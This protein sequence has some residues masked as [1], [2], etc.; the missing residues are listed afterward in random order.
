MKAVKV[1]L[2]VLAIGFGLPVWATTYY[3]SP[4]GGDDG[5]SPERPT[6]LADAVAK[7]TAEGAGAVV[8]LSADTFEQTAQVTIAAD[9]I[10]QGAG[11]DK[12]IVTKN[13][14]SK[15]RLFYLNSAGA[16]LKDMTVQNGN[17]EGSGGNILID[18]NGGLVSNC[19]IRN[20][21]AKNNG[22]GGGGIA[23]K[24]G[25]VVDSIITNNTFDSTQMYEH[26][27]G[28]VYF[29]G[30]SKA[31]IRRCVVAR[32]F[33]KCSGNAIVA[34]AGIGVYSSGK[35]VVIDSCTIA[36]NS[37]S[38]SG[39]V[40]SGC[41]GTLV[42]NCLFTGNISR[43][44][45][46]DYADFYNKNSNLTIKDCFF[47]ADAAYT[48]TNGKKGYVAFED[49]SFTPNFASDNVG[50]AADGSDIGAVQHRPV[51]ALTGYID[52]STLKY[53]APVEVTLTAHATDEN[54]NEMTA[55]V[56]DF[57]DNS[58]SASGASVT[59]D[60]SVA[61]VYTPKATVTVDGVSKVISGKPIDVGPGVV[62]VSS[63]GDLKAAVDSAYPG[64]TVRVGP[65][66]YTLSTTTAMPYD[67]NGSTSI[68][69]CKPVKVIAESVNPYDTV[70]TVTKDSTRAFYLN[71]DAALV[72]GFTIKGGKVNGT[73]HFGG[74]VLVDYGMVSN[75]VMCGC[76]STS[77]GSGGAGVGM[78]HGLVTH[79]II[80]NNTSTITDYDNNG[81]AVNVYGG[82]MRNCLIS[83]NTGKNNG[84]KYVNVGGVSMTGGT[85]ENCTIAGNSAPGVGGVWLRS[86]SP[87]VRN[88]A[89]HDNSSTSGNITYDQLRGT[90]SYFVNCASTVAISGG[91]KCVKGNI[92]VASVAKQ[93]WH[94]QIGTASIGIGLV[95]GWMTD[96]KD[97]DGN[98]M[99]SEEGK[100]DAG[101]W[102]FQ[103]TYL[104][105][106][107]NA[108]S[109][110]GVY[111]HAVVLTA[112]GECEDPITSYVWTFG[113][114]SPSETTTTGAI[115]HVY[116]SAGVYKPSVKFVVESTGRSADFQL[117]DPID[118]GYP[119]FYVTD[120]ENAGTA[121]PWG[122]W[123]TATT[124]LEEVIPYAKNGSVITLSAGTHYTVGQVV[125][126]HGVT[127]EGFDD[128]PAQT[129]VTLKSGS[130][131]HRLFYIDHPKAVLRG[132]AAQ[133]NK[134]EYNVDGSVIYVYTSGG[135]V[136]NC[137]IRGGYQ[138]SNGI[139]GGGII[140]F[141]GTLT[142][143]VVSN[144]VG[145]STHGYG[146][147]GAA[148]ALWGNSS[149]VDYC[150]ITG[151]RTWCTPGGTG[152]E[153][154]NGANVLMSGGTLRNCTIV[155]N[156]AGDNESK[157]DRA[158]FGGVSVYSTSEQNKIV[159][160][161][162]ASN[163]SYGAVG[164]STA[165]RRV[166]NGNAINVMRDC[167]TDVD[168]GKA[169]CFFAEDMKF[170]DA[171]NG[172][173]RVHYQSVAAKN[174][175]ASVIKATRDL[176]GAPTVY[177][178]NK[179]DIGCY[180]RADKPGM[181]LMVR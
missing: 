8:Q 75:C 153:G 142:H 106:F 98:P 178:R 169:S 141:S 78:Y 74:A 5:S 51:T 17:I 114:G 121:F 110:E 103:S 95:Q 131:K 63:G 162:I 29:V 163:T 3:A 58:A 15:F 67:V 31:A 116:A 134:S 157:P 166:A 92:N 28:A 151:N 115:A 40:Y 132:L 158:G 57:G 12:T 181:V 69:L 80:S 20:G 107:L 59:H 33:A 159:N 23:L 9:I 156:R 96:A 150:L 25:E 22:N 36:Y 102:Q 140:L 97:L 125:L 48:G 76:T 179:A 128:D 101:C 135:T 19:V 32:N 111:P 117:A 130:A 123:T 14:S 86:G 35:G 94:P 89:I 37:G 119:H 84:G 138:A 104:S 85:L 127:V 113:D 7:A 55:C 53:A 177:L 118:V 30:S 154:K 144:N 49:N 83:N 38:R 145:A 126:K 77:N 173:W 170:V 122:D 47:D 34:T 65:G 62:S 39:G 4:A 149:L 129:V 13:A 6:T 82:T 108:D 147:S 171:A 167:A 18:T 44:V 72:S 68:Q 54:G 137:I 61:G 26:S 146:H 2:A 79:S 93:D 71:D 21:A 143:S 66:P 105:G 133:G 120:K 172:D 99:L 180:A 139:R 46:H 45:G 56:W 70:I 1:G 165:L 88:C 164:D 27:C 175:D 174:A 43:R 91:N 161:L 50:K 10:V 24:G 160:C 112:S 73:Y 168:T 52:A 136:S 42:T 41:S 124:N 176:A 11:R 100:T 155:G 90:G 60:Y 81:G 64:A 148:V 87:T 152:N 109:T 16:V